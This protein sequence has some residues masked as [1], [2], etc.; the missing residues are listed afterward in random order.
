MSKGY[1]E[2]NLMHFEKLKEY[3]IIKQLYYDKKY[4]MFI[5]QATKYL[6]DYPKNIEMRFMRAKVY[7]KLKLYDD[8]ISDLKYILSIEVNNYALTEIYFLYYYMHM[9]KEA[10]ELLPFLYETRCINTYSLSISELVMKKELGIHMR[11]SKGDKCDYIRTQIFNYSTKLA[12]E[13]IKCHNIDSMENQK[14]KSY[15][16]DNV[17]IDYLYEMVTENIDN[18]K[19]VN[20]DEILEIHY[21]STPSIGIYHDEICNFIKVV[22]VPNTNHIITMYPTN[23]VEPE[24]IT[25]IN[26]DDSKLFIKKEKEKVKSISRIDKFNTKYGR[27]Q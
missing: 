14:D 9:Y 22:V 4:S 12:I 18:N 27:V 10:I 5:N 20:T 11:V 25:Y 24:F 6:E 13:H 2:S 3:K 7:R 23:H 26:Y 19:K 17:N 21:F 1:K 16:N 8:A 15:F